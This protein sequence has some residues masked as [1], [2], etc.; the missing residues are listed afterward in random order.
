VEVWIV[1]QESLF[2]QVMGH[3]HV[4][5]YFLSDIWYDLGAP[6]Y[7][8]GIGKTAWGQKLVLVLKLVVIENASL[9]S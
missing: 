2:S 9:H 4:A 1:N 6:K 8:W 5:N 3:D 7:V